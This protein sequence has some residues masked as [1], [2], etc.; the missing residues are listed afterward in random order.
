MSVTIDGFWINDQIV[1]FEVFTAVTMKNVVF[2][3]VA[4]CKSCVNRRFGGT[5]SLHLQ[6]R[7]ICK[8]GISE[9]EA[10]DW[11]ISRNHWW[12]S[13]QPPAHTGSS[14]IDFSTLKMEAIQTSVY[15]SINK[16]T[17]LQDVPLHPRCVHSLLIFVNK[18]Y[19]NNYNTCFY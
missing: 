3:D 5:Y 8:Q 14:L 15:S 11:A 6:G 19:S 9:Q 13:L 12:L 7:K 18:Q 1:R 17:P 2:W 10:A 16:V 4:L